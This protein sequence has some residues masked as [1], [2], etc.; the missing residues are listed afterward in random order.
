M[1]GRDGTREGAASYDGAVMRAGVVLGLVVVATGL[2]ACDQV[3]ALLPGSSEPTP[4]AS[5]TASAVVPEGDW[6]AT[7]AFDGKWRV[8]ASS[9]Y[10][11]GGFAFFPLLG[12]PVVIEGGV[13]AFLANATGQQSQLRKTL[14]VTGS[15]GDGGQ[16]VLLQH[17]GT[18]YDHDAMD[19]SAESVDA[20]S[21]GWSRHGLVRKDGEAIV[22]V[23][24][25]VEGPAPTSSSQL[26]EGGERVRLVPYVEE[27]EVAA[28]PAEE[29][30]PAP[31]TMPADATIT[32]E[33]TGP[34]EPEPCAEY[35]VSFRGDGQMTVSGPSVGDEPKVVRLPITTARTIW[36]QLRVEQFFTRTEM[37][38]RPPNSRDGELV[39]TWGESSRKLEAAFFPRARSIADKLANVKP[40]AP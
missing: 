4:E 24:A 14:R 5:A 3:S 36:S 2:L 19:A 30:P 31:P 17:R 35:T 34:C 18:F 16:R 39:V 11:D 26:P 38:E 8:A 40:P 12:A 32:F 7:T 28:A 33:T 13:M 10:R 15:A 27:P 9:G 21:E 20:T 37:P 29:L 23:L 6:Q 1:R 25:P 22:L